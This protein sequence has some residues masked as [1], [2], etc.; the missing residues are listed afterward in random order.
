MIGGVYLV[1][2]RAWSWDVVVAG[3]PFG[4]STA[5]INVGKHIDKSGEDRRKGV[6]TLPVLVGE[7]AAR[8]LNMAAIILA[9]AVTLYMIAVP[10]FFT[11]VL[12]IVFF[13]A[14]L[15][16]NALRRLSRPRPREAP[17][18]YPIWPRWF[19]TVAFVHNRRFGNLFIL[20]VA[21]DTI[22]RLV[23]PAFWR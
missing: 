3:I 22:V 10:R 23:F 1:L 18:G 12:L 13:A 15:G 16:W 17:P 8:F 14:P 21:L 5:S 7:A 11:P 6:T 4:L 20:G 2:T 9:Y 19:S